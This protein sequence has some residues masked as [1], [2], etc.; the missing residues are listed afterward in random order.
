MI[1]PL[2]FCLSAK[3][4][5]ELLSM[6]LFQGASARELRPRSSPNPFMGSARLCSTSLIDRFVKPKAPKGHFEM[7]SR[8]MA[9]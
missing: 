1:L 9:I 7:T 6:S 8:E 5:R 2:N 4:A 3:C